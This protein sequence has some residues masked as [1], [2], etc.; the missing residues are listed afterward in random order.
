M[1]YNT[2]LK[3]GSKT[4]KVETSLDSD[5]F[6]DL[7]DKEFEKDYD[8]KTVSKIFYLMFLCSVSVN[9][10]H[11]SLPACSEEVKSKMNILNFGFGALGTVV[12]FGLT[13]GSLMGAQVYSNSKNIKFVL[14]LSLTVMAFTLMVFALC[15]KFEVNVVMRFIAGICQIFTIIYVPLW[16]DAFGNER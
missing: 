16:A 13:L 10:D 1:D 14:M 11:G 7:V 5:E 8:K 3:D 4:E 12:Y 2:D 6:Q 15:S 9:L